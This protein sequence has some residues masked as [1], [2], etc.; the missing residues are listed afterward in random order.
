MTLY[1]LYTILGVSA[2]IGASMFVITMLLQGV[3][4]KGMRKFQQRVMVRKQLLGNQLQAVLHRK[5]SPH[6][7]IIFFGESKL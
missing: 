3:I 6:F 7:L 1:F 4:A 2:L 5:I